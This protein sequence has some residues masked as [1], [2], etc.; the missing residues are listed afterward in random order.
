MT[1]GQLKKILD[2][3][4]LLLSSRPQKKENLKEFY[5]MEMECG[6]NVL[7][8]PDF[9]IFG[10]QTDLLK[11]TVE[12]AGEKAFSAACIPPVPGG[13]ALY[14]GK[15]SY[16][17]YYRHILVQAQLCDKTG[18]SFLLLGGFSNLTEAKCAVFAAKEACSLPLCVGL[19]FGDDLCLESGIDPAKAVITLQ[20]LGVNAIGV[21][22]DSSADDTLELLAQMKEFSAVPLFAIPGISEFMT[23]EAFGEYM[24]EYVN[25]KAA[26]LGTINGGPAYTAAVSK[27]IWQLEPF[28]PDFYEVNAVTGIHDI[29]FYDFN[30]QV[31]GSKKRLLE[32]SIE[33]EEETEAIIKKLI[34]AQAPP[35]C[36]K[37]K[38]LDA[39]E[40]AL[41]LYPGRPAVSSDEY[42]EI[43][44]KEFGAFVM[45][46]QEG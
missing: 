12:A 28:R 35:V 11:Q 36:F 10:L 3:N 32:I 18:I 4:L 15:N 31:I 16:E 38:D 21:L 5:E 46:K 17:D 14:G 45:P 25:Y 22:S 42:G 13:L 30:G 6:A 7:F 37:S 9:R 27:N 39:L 26:I 43:A 1:R 29:F 20:A 33:K 23:P 8:A 40:R 19:S 34:S 24:P 44:A 41:K 2:C